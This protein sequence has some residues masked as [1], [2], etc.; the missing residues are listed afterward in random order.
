MRPIAI[1]LAALLALSV[2]SLFVGV[3]ELGAGDEAWALMTISRV[4]RLMAVLITGAGLAICGSILQVLVRNRFVDPMT[5]GTGQGAALGILLVTIFL[6]SAP[7]LVKMAVAS[8]TALAASVGFLLI[9]QRLPPTQPY[10]VALV[11]L[12]YG[13][14]IGA[15]VTFVAYQADLLQFIDIWTQGE[16]SGVL[17]GRYELLWLA[18]GVAA[19]S[20]LAAD[21]FAILGMGRTASI[22]LGLN[23]GQVTLIG[24]SGA[25]LVL[26]ADIL[27]RLLRYPFEIPVGTVL[28]I[29]GAVLFLWL[30]YRPARHA[31]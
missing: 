22:N 7:V 25:A 18:A 27:G 28:G 15:G 4:P 8:A 12:I 13:G 5:V 21:Q 1:G 30:L 2:L 20:Y 31:R 16:F 3:A 14:I 24:C 29:L 19:L 10:L 23:Y 9:A 6:P 17:Q 11:G 26:G